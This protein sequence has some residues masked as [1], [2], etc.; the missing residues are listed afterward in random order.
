MCGVLRCRKRYNEPL[1]GGLS[2]DTSYNEASPNSNNPVT[3]TSILFKTKIP[4]TPDPGLVAN[5]KKYSDNSFS[6][7][8]ISGLFRL[9]V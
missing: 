5:G 1:V 6:I 9:Y 4:T 8:L 7:N 3:C 2:G